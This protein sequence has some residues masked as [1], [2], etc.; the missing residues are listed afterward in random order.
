MIHIVRLLPVLLRSAKYTPSAKEVD[1]LTRLINRMRFLR[2]NSSSIREVAR[3]A[4]DECKQS[5]QSVNPTV[6]LFKNKWGWDKEKLIDVLEALWKEI[7]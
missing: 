4:V 6:E 3:K 7:K 2:S 1:I 5:Y